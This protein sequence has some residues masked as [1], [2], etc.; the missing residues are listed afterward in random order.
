MLA[1][2]ML[3]ALFGQF[4][5]GLIVTATWLVKADKLETKS[6]DTSICTG[7]STDTEKSGQPPA[8]IFMRIRSASARRVRQI[9]DRALKYMRQK[10]FLINISRL[11]VD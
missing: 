3:I 8:G 2:S 10:L 5:N 4:G 1:V 7:K 9:I 11:Q 6:K